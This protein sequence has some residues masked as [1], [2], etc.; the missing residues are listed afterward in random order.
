MTLLVGHLPSTTD[1]LVIGTGFGGSVMAS[2][3]AEGGR[4]V[5]VLER[6]KAYPRGPSPA[7]RPVSA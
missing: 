3:L 6:G 2:R 1:V 5:C 7:A 4:D